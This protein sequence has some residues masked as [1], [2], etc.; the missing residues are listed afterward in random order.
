[1][2]ISITASTFVMVPLLEQHPGIRDLPR[3]AIIC[4]PIFGL[5]SIAGIGYLWSMQFV[6]Q[7]GNDIIAHPRSIFIRT[8]LGLS[9]AVLFS[10]VVYIAGIFPTPPSYVSLFTICLSMGIAMWTGTS[11]RI[12][13]DAVV[14]LIR[15]LWRVILI[16]VRWLTATITLVV[17]YLVRTIQS[18]LQILGFPGRRL[19]EII[20][21]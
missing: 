4:I 15:M 16:T 11:L 3:V 14:A 6:M 20:F 13:L 2:A 9:A 12:V 19:Y 8:A 5:L 17:F 7:I 1:M 18:L 21:T 10:L